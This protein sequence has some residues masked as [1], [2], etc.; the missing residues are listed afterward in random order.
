M[1][2]IALQLVDDGRGTIVLHL[3]VRFR[4][5]LGA[6]ALIVILAMVV[7]G[8]VGIVPLLIVATL[9]V[10][11]SY[12]ERWI[13]DSTRRQVEGRHGLVFLAR[14]RRWSYD[15]LRA[16]E[17]HS[18]RIG[19]IPGVTP[20]SDGSEAD[21]TP[22]YRGAM[23]RMARRSLLRYGLR[24]SDG[25]VA[26]IEIRRVRD[27]EADIAIPKILARHLDLPIERTSI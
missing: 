12:E 3:G 21:A 27:F 1:I 14:T 11:A 2:N 18:Y 23:G 22:S 19:S 26:Q 17:Y 9:L 10:G 24:T 13:F 5:L 8:E 15:D 20:Q 6:L 16:V 4:V 25:D 7:G